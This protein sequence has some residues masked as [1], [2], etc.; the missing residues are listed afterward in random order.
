MLLFKL[1]GLGQKRRPESLKRPKPRA[2]EDVS[3]SLPDSE[4]VR[5]ER[6]D[7]S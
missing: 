5:R 3:H 6:E 7:R 1:G 2:E 4:R